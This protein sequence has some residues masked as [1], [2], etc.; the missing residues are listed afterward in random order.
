MNENNISPEGVNKLQSV[1]DSPEIFPTITTKSLNRILIDLRVIKNGLDK[2]K[3]WAN[4]TDKGISEDNTDKRDYAT[5]ITEYTEEIKALIE[6]G[7]AALYEEIICNGKVKGSKSEYDP[8]ELIGIIVD[9]RNGVKSPSAITRTDNYR[10]KVE[11][12]LSFKI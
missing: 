6:E 11:K 8:Q 3:G 7:F 10:Q 9:V 1:N 12:L 2:L 4:E 5:R